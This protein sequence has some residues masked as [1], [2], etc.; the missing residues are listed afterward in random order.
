MSTTS[1]ID[2]TKLAKLIETEEA[3]FNDR[4]HKSREMTERAQKSLAGGVA[5]SWQATDPTRSTW[6][7][8]TGRR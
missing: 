8:G 5:S 6:P 3:I 4:H 1:T 7:R 2:S